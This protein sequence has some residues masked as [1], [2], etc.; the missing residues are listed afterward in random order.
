[1]GIFSRFADIVNANVNSLLDKA[2]D[3]QKLI[4]LIIQEMEDT[5]VEVRTSSARALADKKELQRRIQA[6][7]SQITD[8][9]EKASLALQK[10]REDLARAALIEKQKLADVALTL[11][12]EYKLVE[13]TIEKLSLEVAELERKLQETRA[14]QQALVTRHKAAGTRRDVR[15]QLD[16]SKVDEAMSK[17]EQYERRIDEMEAEADSYSFGRGKS[18]ESE[19]ADLQAQDEIEKELERLKANIKDKE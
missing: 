7:E 2:E 6:I 3:P 11:N 8:W 9:Q 4:R 13:E 19:F 14:R 18:L 15:R 1:M 17:F 5:L 12:E 10:G 16:T